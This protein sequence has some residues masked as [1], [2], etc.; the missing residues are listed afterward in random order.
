MPRAKSTQALLI[1]GLRA[2]IDEMKA[3]AADLKAE[4]G[5]LLSD[6]SD[7]AKVYRVEKMQEAAGWDGVVVFGFGPNNEVM[8][9]STMILPKSLEVVAAGREILIRLMAPQ[10]DGHTY[11]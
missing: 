7:E 11:H 2:E 1:E 8:A 10:P 3:D 9:Y 6:T 4:L 5:K